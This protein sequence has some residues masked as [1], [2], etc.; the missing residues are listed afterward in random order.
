V[1]VEQQRLGAWVPIFNVFLIDR[2]R[3]CAGEYRD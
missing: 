1:K 3:G 2:E